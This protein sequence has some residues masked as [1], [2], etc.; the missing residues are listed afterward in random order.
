MVS[1]VNASPISSSDP[2]FFHDHPDD[3]PHGS[4]L[5]LGAD[6]Q[7]EQDHHDRHADAVVETAFQI[8]R[9]AHRRRH[10]RIGNDRFAERRVGRRQY[11]GQQGH[12]QDFEPGKDDG[13]DDKA[14]HDRQGQTERQQPLR[15]PEVPFDDAEIRVGGVGEQNHGERQFCQKPQPLTVDADAQNAQPIGA[16]DKPDRGEHD[17]AA[18]QRAL[19]P[20]RD[21]AVDEQEYGQNRAVLVHRTPV[22]FS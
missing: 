2:D 10:C 8:E 20:S 1:Q 15:Q 18:D 11:R 7:S 12:L 6:R 4:A 13:G 5:D 21:R 19:D 16:Q 22:A 3:V 14:E 17:R 9:F